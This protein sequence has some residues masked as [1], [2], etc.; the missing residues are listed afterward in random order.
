MTRRDFLGAVG[1][2]VAGAFT[3]DL[4]GQEQETQKE[5]KKPALRLIDIGFEGC[6]YCK[7]IEPIIDAL[8]EKAPK[9]VVEKVDLNLSLIHI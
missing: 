6:T 1:V 7:Q 4:F 9:G 5:A 8:K 2:F 3:K